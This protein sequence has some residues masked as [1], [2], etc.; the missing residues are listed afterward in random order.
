MDKI[1][2]FILIISKMLIPLKEA[3]VK[4]DLYA[5]YSYRVEECFKPLYQNRLRFALEAIKAR[6]PLRVIHS[7]AELKIAAVLERVIREKF[8]EVFR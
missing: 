6:K 5:S 8:I 3:F 2:K 7:G 1:F 4:I